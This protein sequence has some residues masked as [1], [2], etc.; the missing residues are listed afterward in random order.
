MVR[1]SKAVVHNLEVERRDLGEEPA[2]KCNPLAGTAEKR[3]LSCGGCPEIGQFVPVEGDRPGLA[4]IDK[5]EK[6]E[7]SSRVLVAVVDHVVDRIE[8]HVRERASTAAAP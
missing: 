8:S 3:A 6:R 5:R 4:G 7:S 1:S 2:L